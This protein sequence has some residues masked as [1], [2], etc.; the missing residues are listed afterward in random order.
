M[1][2]PNQGRKN[3]RLAVL[4]MALT[5]GLNSVAT[6][7]DEAAAPAKSG[8]WFPWLSWNKPADESD[9]N[10][11]AAIASLRPNGLKRLGKWLFGPSKSKDVNAAS[12]SVG[13]VHVNG[14]AAPVLGPGSY[15]LSSKGWQSTKSPYSR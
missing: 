1:T 7:Q 15:K 10:Q 13:D 4:A 14:S 2:V 6:A 9:R 3:R 11:V 8:G 5:L 12:Y